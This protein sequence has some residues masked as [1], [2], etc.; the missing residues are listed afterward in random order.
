MKQFIHLGW[1]MLL[2]LVIGPGCKKKK[3][4]GCTEATMT[5][6][7]S[8]ADGSVEPASVGPEFP[9]AV[10]VTANL[11]TSGVSIVVS[12]RPEGATSTPFFSDTLTNVTQQT[13][14]FMIVGTPANS[15]AVVDITVT[16][17]SC[18]TN[19]WTGTYRYSMT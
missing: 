4:G 17:N 10:N 14:N 15:A 16:S 18:N 11:P 2:L 7:S 3:D 5:V 1:V 8:P 6:T 13:S 19:T 9:V 12:A